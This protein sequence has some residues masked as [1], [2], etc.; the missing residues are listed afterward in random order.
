MHVR[1]AHI[2]CMETGKPTAR[3]MDMTIREQV[4]ELAQENGHFELAKHM[5]YAA[6]NRANFLARLNWLKSQ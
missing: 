3:K 2:D 6:Y 4:I 5:V 1:I